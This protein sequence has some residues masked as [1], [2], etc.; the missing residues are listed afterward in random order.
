MSVPCMTHWLTLNIAPFPL[1][2]EF[3]LP[4]TIPFDNFCLKMKGNIKINSLLLHISLS[5]HTQLLHLVSHF[6]GA[7]YHLHNVFVK[8][9]CGYPLKQWAKDLAQIR[10]PLYHYQNHHQA[11]PQNILRVVDSGAST[12]SQHV[13]CVALWWCVFNVVRSGFDVTMMSYHKCTEWV[14]SSEMPVRR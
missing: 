1:L 5:C 6:T 2:R 4:H 13:L 7:T 8:L 10:L 11:Y 3:P 9:N 14:S 12:H